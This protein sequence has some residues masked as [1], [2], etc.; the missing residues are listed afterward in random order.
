MDCWTGKHAPAGRG[1]V[2]HLPS[3]GHQVPHALSELTVKGVRIRSGSRALRSVFGF[4]VSGS[5]VFASEGLCDPFCVW[6]R[7]AIGLLGLELRLWG[8]GVQRLRQ[9]A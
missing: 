8:Q 6:R 7:R 3:A 2:G 9:G 5:G 4:R 1:G